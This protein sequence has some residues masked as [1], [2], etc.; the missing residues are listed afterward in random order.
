MSGS[1]T[2]VS[3]QLNRTCRPL[4]CLTTGCPCRH[5][6]TDKG[7]DCGQLGACQPCSTVSCDAKN[8]SA[9][10]TVFQPKEAK[11]RRE[12]PPTGSS[13]NPGRP[14]SRPSCGAGP[15][16]RAAAPSTCTGPSACKHCICARANKQLPG[17]YVGAR[18]CTAPPGRACCLNAVADC[19][20]VRCSRQA[21]MQ[22]KTC[23]CSPK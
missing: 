3:F 7:Q 16:I 12:R 11:A 23:T 9:S 6:G 15:A 10:T 21:L 5:R 4:N 1:S 8:L 13:C 2:S 18:S 19:R 14:A 20:Q 17:G 22:G